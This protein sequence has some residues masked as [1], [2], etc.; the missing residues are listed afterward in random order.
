MSLDNRRKKA[1]ET[2]KKLSVKRRRLLAVF[3]DH[4]VMSNRRKDGTYYG[5]TMEE[6]KEVHQTLMDV[7]QFLED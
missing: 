4:A 2:L 7:R 5:M 1:I 6:T 3:F